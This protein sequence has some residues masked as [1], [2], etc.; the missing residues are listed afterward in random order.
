MCQYSRSLYLVTRCLNASSLVE[1]SFRL[2]NICWSS[3][4]LETI[5]GD[6]TEEWENGLMQ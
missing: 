5:V 4:I 2:S 3:V 6:L 1:E